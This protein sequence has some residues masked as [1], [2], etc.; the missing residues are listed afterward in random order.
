MGE[1]TPRTIAR[2]PG[3]KD[4]GEYVMTIGNGLAGVRMMAIVGIVPGHD[5]Y[6]RSH[7]WR[8]YASDGRHS[9]LT[10]FGDAREL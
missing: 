6:V 7:R 8:R 5:V 10:G 1:L 2:L 9:K 3:P 4:G